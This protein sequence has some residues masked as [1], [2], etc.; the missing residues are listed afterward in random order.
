MGQ[1]GAW[2]LPAC[3]NQRHQ[4]QNDDLASI[5]FLCVV[6]EGASL[7][8]GAS[9]EREQHRSFL[10]ATNERV[11][12]CSYLS[13]AFN[14]TITCCP[15]QKTQSAFADKLHIKA[16]IILPLLRIARSKQDPANRGT[17]PKLYTQ[18]PESRGKHSFS[19][20]PCHNWSLL[21]AAHL[22]AVT[23]RQNR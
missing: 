16:F 5:R 8:L 3:K 22:M 9:Q 13:R 11:H 6:L 15:C 14:T 17:M 21:H 23:G 10:S 12:L 19:D 2:H 20:T 1:Q 18:A 7:G 4:S